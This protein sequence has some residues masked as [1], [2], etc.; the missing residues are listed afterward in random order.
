MRLLRLRITK[1]Y[2][3]MRRRMIEETELALFIGLCF[4]E[5]VQRIPTMEVGGARFHPTFAARFWQDVL[6]LD[7][8]EI[9]L[10]RR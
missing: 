10:L 1:G 4:P 5:R 2:A 6:D 9:A 7:E 8:P 3:E